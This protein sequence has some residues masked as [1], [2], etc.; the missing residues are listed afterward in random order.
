MG[1]GVQSPIT[2]A[3]ADVTAAFLETIAH[4]SAAVDEL[5]TI[6]GS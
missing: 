5:Q 3:G 6:G 4:E 2:G 1:L